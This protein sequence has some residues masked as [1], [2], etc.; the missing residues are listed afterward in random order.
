M[1]LSSQMRSVRPSTIDILR[2]TLV[3]LESARE[4]LIDQRDNLMDGF[5]S[6][7]DDVTE[8]IINI[9]VAIA[10]AEKANSA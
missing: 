10:I 1:S 4:E 7:I 2:D 5:Q 9:R 6:D 3:E 8:R